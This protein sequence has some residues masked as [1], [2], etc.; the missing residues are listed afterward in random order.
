MEYYRSFM[1]DYNTATMPHLK[2]Y[3]YE[4]WEIAEYNKTQEEKRRAH[5]SANQND[6]NVDFSFNDE[7]AVRLARKKQKAQEEAQQ[8]AQLHSHMKQDK[9]IQQDMKKQ[10]ELQLQL[11]IAHKRGDS[12][13]V[14]RLE[15]LLAPDDPSKAP[16]VKHPWG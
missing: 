3:Q 6:G 5:L 10:S 13:T 15:K 11:Q 9:S 4:K 2:F 14:K 7:E 1:E 8:F 12:T 16:V